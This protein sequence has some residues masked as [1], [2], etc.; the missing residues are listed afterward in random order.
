MKFK[1]ADRMKDRLDSFK[2]EAQNFWMSCP[3]MTNFYLVCVP[4]NL[5]L[6]SDAYMS[7]A[8]GTGQCLAYQ[9]TQL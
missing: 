2:I 7:G 3:I 6:I 9:G 4:C 1:I 5:E 8:P